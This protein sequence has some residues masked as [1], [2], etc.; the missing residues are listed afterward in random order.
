ML[1]DD[2]LSTDELRRLKRTI[3]DSDPKDLEPDVFTAAENEAA[4]LAR[5]IND[6]K[7]RPN[8]VIEDMIMTKI[9]RSGMSGG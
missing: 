8:E 5:L 2:Y 6:K 4:H 7:G 3:A 1:G 9:I